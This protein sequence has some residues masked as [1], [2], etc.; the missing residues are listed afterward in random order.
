M[1]WLIIAMCLILAVFL[2]LYGC[3]RV[4]FSVPQEKCTDLYRLPDSEQFAPF[5]EEIGREI[6]NALTI[7]FERVSIRSF[8]GVTLSGRYYEKTPGAPVDIMFHGY[9][10]AG[11]RDFC[12]GM[13]AALKRGHNVLVVD[14]RA[15]CESGGRCLTFGIKERRDCLEWVKF[16]IGRCGENAEIFLFGMSMGAATVLMAA[17]LDLPENVKGILADCGYTSPSEILKTVMKANGFSPR[18]IYPAVRLAGMIF[19]GVDV[20]SASASDAMTRCKIPVLFIHGDDDRFV[21]CDMSRENHRLCT[22]DKKRLFI[23]AGAGH[24]MSYFSG[25]EEYLAE[26]DSFCRE[27]LSATRPG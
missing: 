25:R 26:I 5:R 18:L 3:Y 15:H 27:C 14:Q 20:E 16:I 10:S 11:L 8:D 1:I 24:A 13:P 21:P 4:V 6:D 22:A 19:A 2:A 7:P 23:A 12:V 9:R 17:G